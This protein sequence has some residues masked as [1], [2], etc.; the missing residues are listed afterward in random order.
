MPHCY[1]RVMPE[2]PEVETV[3][4]DLQPLL[5][6]KCIVSMRVGKHKLRHPWKPRWTKRVTGRKVAA[7]R[8]RGKW[9]IIDLDNDSHLLA[10][11]GMTG[12]F[13]VEPPEAKTGAHTHLIFT[14][15][16]GAQ[17]RFRDVR[18]F[19]S[20]RHCATST[21][22][23]R[24]LASKLG[25]EPWELTPDRWLASLKATSRCLKAVLLDQHI[26]AGVGNIY[27]DEALFAARLAPRQRGRR[28]SPEQAEQLRLAIVA[29]LDRAIAAR[30]TTFRDYVG[31]N[32]QAGGFQH[33]L[34][35]YGRASEACRE[36]GNEIRLTRLAG[37]STH[38]CP[39]CQPFRRM[40]RRRAVS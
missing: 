17:L 38:Y 15:D 21:E 8:R 32:G 11:L 22:L 20:V 9:I 13:T 34:A 19:G 24:E 29:V 10:H 5:V 7:L 33:A 25:P 16:S 2:L 6:S 28:T 30:G 1:N 31:G 36:C 40:Q 12:R 14:L 23:E 37:R 35:V 3:V 26:V 18:R 39:N 27:A 4:R